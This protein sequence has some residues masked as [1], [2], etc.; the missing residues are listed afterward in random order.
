MKNVISVEFNI[1]GCE[2]YYQDYLSDRSLFDADII[3]FKP[4]SF[5]QKLKNL[6]STHG[7]QITQLGL[8]M[9]L[10]KLDA[11]YKKEMTEILKNGKNIFLFMS[12]YEEFTDWIDEKEYNNYK[13]LP[14]NARII[15]RNGSE[16]RFNN[17]KNFCIFWKEFNPYLNYECYIDYYYNYNNQI[18]KVFITNSGDKLLG[19]ICNYGQGNLI[20]NFVQ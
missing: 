9:H 1:P 18:E 8:I 17:E 2:K 12:K 14:T 5:Y 13:F 19:G 16:I 3:I 20:L 6:Q 11:Q 4:I 15:S 10:E 7:Q